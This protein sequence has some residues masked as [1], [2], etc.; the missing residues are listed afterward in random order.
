LIAQLVFEAIVPKSYARRV[1]TPNHLKPARAQQG[2]NSPQAKILVA[3]SSAASPKSREEELSSS[4]AQLG[5]AENKLRE[6]TADFDEQKRTLLSYQKDFQLF[7]DKINLHEQTIQD[8][9]ANAKLLNDQIIKAQEREAALVQQASSSQGG[10]DQQYVL[11]LKHELEETTKAL[12]E[13]AGHVTEKDRKIA[14]L[15]KTVDEIKPIADNFANE[16]AK[17]FAEISSRE[18]KFKK[19]KAIFENK[20]QKEAKGLRDELTEAKCELLIKSKELAVARAQETRNHQG[21]REQLSQAAQ[22]IQDKVGQLQEIVRDRDL[23]QKEATDLGA[24]CQSLALDRDQHK[25]RAEQAE[26]LAQGIEAKD[27][28]LAQAHQEIEELRQQARKEFDALQ[29]D[30]ETKTKE[31]Q[32]EKGFVLKLRAEAEDLKKIQSH[33]VSILEKNLKSKNE[34]LGSLQSSL[35]KT[36]S[37]EVDVVE[38]LKKQLESKTDEL[39]VL[40]K[41]FPQLKTEVEG[42]R[43]KSQELDTLKEQVQL[44]EKTIVAKDQDLAKLASKAKGLTKTIRKLK[45][46]LQLAKDESRPATNEALDLSPLRASLPVVDSQ[47]AD[48]HNK[49]PPKGESAEVSALN[50]KIRSQEKE[51]LELYREGR[52]QQK[53]LAEK[54]TRI[55]CL[56]DANNEW[57]RAWVEKKANLTKW[58]ASRNEYKERTLVAEKYI[59]D[60]LVAVC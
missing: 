10:V 42:L 29:G 1:T 28:K 27:T 32:V 35:S 4:R 2:R 41:H 25:A 19:E 55:R 47:P 53:E 38:A 49:T 46:E 36:K 44:H 26:T 59:Q 7:V 54:D 31:L 48:L 52:A 14:E 22:E 39:E 23:W 57:Q 34:E 21:A 5:A 40:Q 17:A 6:L 60:H 33:Q 37:D 20:C 18:F 58:K 51:L 15:Q 3:D 24:L 43:S 9:E 11:K 13:V 56:A 45:A 50:K 12:N 16:K 30:L 8:H